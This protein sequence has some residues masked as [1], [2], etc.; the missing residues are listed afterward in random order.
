MPGSADRLGA[1]AQQGMA[2]RPAL[3]VEATAVLTGADVT[4]EP[5]GQVALVN[6]SETGALLEAAMRPAVGTAVWLRL[7]SAGPA[8]IAGRVVRT[9]VSAIHADETLRYQ[10]GVAFETRTPVPLKAGPAH[11]AHHTIDGAPELTATPARPG[12]EPI[13][14]W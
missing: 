13:N 12:P 10:L 14:Q 11:L 5:F 3:R 7:D 8:G 6:L 4:L 2:P 9:R 1:P